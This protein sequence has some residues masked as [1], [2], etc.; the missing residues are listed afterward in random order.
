[1]LAI[2]PTMSSGIISKTSCGKASETRLSPRRLL[3]L[4]DP[5]GEV[6]FAD[7]LLLPNGMSKVGV[8]VR[9]WPMRS[10]SLSIG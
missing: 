2:S 8:Y 5:A 3:T 9:R 4:S 7:V 1:M 6:L 10:F